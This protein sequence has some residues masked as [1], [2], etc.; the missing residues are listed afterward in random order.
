M[1]FNVRTKYGK[2]WERG[3]IF[4]GCMTTYLHTEHSALQA[5]YKNADVGFCFNFLQ[6]YFVIL[7]N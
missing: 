4:K 1:F 7:T 6:L 5:S 2:T 3:Y